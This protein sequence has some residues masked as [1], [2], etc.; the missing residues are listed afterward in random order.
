MNKKEDFARRA[1]LINQRK[2]C[3]NLS[4]RAI[5]FLLNLS[6]SIEFLQKI[7]KNFITLNDHHDP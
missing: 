2:I 3:L 5:D 1:F 6:G 7:L 4:K